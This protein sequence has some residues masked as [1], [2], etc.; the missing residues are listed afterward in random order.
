MVFFVKITPMLCKEKKSI[1]MHTR[2]LKRKLP[3]ICIAICKNI[4][5]ETDSKF[6]NQRSDWKTQVFLDFNSNIPRP[7]VK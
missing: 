4:S 1:K 6:W 7:F 3:N 5:A 2:G